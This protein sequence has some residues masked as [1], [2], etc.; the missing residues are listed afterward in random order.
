MPRY[1]TG[2]FCPVLFSLGPDGLRTF[3]YRNLTAPRPAGTL[4]SP[5]VCIDNDRTFHSV[6]IATEFLRPAHSNWMKE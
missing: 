5:I 3:T 2:P 1:S 4:V 6:F